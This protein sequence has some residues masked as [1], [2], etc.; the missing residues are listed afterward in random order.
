LIFVFVD[1]GLAAWNRQ[2]RDALWRFGSR[3]I[4]IGITVAST[5]LVGRPMVAC[6]IAFLAWIAVVTL[7]KFRQN[8]DRVQWSWRMIHGAVAICIYAAVTAAR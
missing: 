7:S 3:F 6:L 1:F 8:A 2:F 5:M 4:A